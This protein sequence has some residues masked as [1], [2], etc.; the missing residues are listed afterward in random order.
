MIFHFENT[1]KTIGQVAYE[2]DL[3]TQPLYH[4][5]SKR[6]AWDELSCHA[7]WSWHNNPTARST[8]NHVSIHHN[9]LKNN[10]GTMTDLNQ[11]LSEH[12]TLRELIKSPEAARLG[13]D[14]TPTPEVIENLT[15][16]CKR[17]LEPVRQKFGVPFTPNSGYRSP[18]LNAAI[19][20]AK[21]SQHMTG[22]AVDIEIPG[23]SNYDL[24]WWI[25][26]Q[27]LFDQVILEH[28]EPGDPHSGWV[29]VSYS[30]T[31]E[32]RTHCLTF[33]GK[34]YKLGLIA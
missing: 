8:E 6:P 5:G 29:H 18:A 13:I 27:L 3:Q 31:G 11:K 34:I 26:K 23:V 25:G 12:F 16:I 17:I 19:G 30:R 14:N 9:M 22:E 28:Y 4:D 24:A 33:D 10:G 32:N 20:G 15:I 7:K 1:G 21:G 2:D